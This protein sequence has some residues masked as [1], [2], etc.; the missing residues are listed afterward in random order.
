MMECG[1]FNNGNF[2]GG[3][4]SLETGISH[5]RNVSHFPL[6]WTPLVYSN[7][8]LFMHAQEYQ[9]PLA[10]LGGAGRAT[11]PFAHR[12]KSHSTVWRNKK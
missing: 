1:Y 5:R 2:R 10:D 6:G 11:V 12:A 8:F 7:L 3:F 9:N 4:C